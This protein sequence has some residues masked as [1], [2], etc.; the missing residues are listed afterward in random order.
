MKINA[1]DPFRS[2]GFVLRY[3]ATGLK[4]PSTCAIRKCRRDGSCTGPMLYPDLAAG[5]FLPARPGNDLSTIGPLCCF[6]L[7]EAGRD[8]V[9]M[10]A[11]K[12]RE[13]H[14]QAPWAELNE[15]TSAIAAR[16]WSGCSI[17]LLAGPPA[18]KPL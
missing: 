7:D 5:R 9:A 15:A 11:G 12:L 18:E 14:E 6:G 2:T 8:R 3:A 1:T 17:A 10:L 16:D 4:L 13:R